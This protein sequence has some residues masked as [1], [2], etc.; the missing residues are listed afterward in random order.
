MA[1]P[2]GFKTKRLRVDCDG[3]ECSTCLTYKPWDSFYPQ[4]NGANKH[5]ATCKECKSKASKEKTAR[6]SEGR[7]RTRMDLDGRECSTCGEF[8][9]WSSFGKSTGGVAG[10]CPSCKE[11]KN[12]NTRKWALA[13]PDKAK[14][15]TRAWISENLEY[16]R[17]RARV[18][19]AKLRAEIGLEEYSRREKEWRLA[20]PERHAAN[21]KRNYAA[22]REELKAKN[23]LDRQNRP[24]A[25]AAY[26]ATKRA[27]RKKGFCPWADQQAIQSIY[28]LA[29]VLTR[30][31]GLKYHV[32]HIIPLVS[33]RV[34]GLHVES[35]LRITCANDNLLKSNKFDPDTFDPNDIPSVH[36]A[37]MREAAPDEIHAKITALIERATS[38]QTGSKQ[39]S[40]T[41][42]Q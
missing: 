39:L 42:N 6:K 19:S 9:P 1:M 3:R 10:K 31:T 33:K 16:V 14:E 23:K 13:N 36:W 24:E 29:Q 37:D 20:N 5:G 11:C 26:D 4:Q 8:K 7:P 38:N 18:S 41:S 27:K 17:E 21:T 32:D 22:H 2:K 12:A 35:N 25:H 30:V 15:A 34:Q 40:P 28:R